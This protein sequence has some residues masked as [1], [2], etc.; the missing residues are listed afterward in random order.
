MADRLLKEN[1]LEFK[2]M[3]PLITETV[4]KIKIISP[5][6]AQTGPASRHDMKIVNDH[7]SLLSGNDHKIYELISKAIQ[8]E[9]L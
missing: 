8:D 9:Q 5:K 3:L 7:L 1:N 4:E 2:T 6:A